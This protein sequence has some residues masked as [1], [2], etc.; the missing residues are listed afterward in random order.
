MIS[1]FETDDQDQ[2]HDMLR[3]TYT[4]MRITVAGERHH[5][6]IRRAEVGSIELHRLLLGMRFTADVAPMTLVP[7]VRIASG[8]LAQWSSAQTDHYGPGDLFVGS[9]LDHSFRARVDELDGEHARLPPDLLAQVADAAPGRAPRPIQ[10]TGH[11]PLSRRAASVWNRSYDYV[12]DNVAGLSEEEQPLLVG[13]AV[14]LLAAV[15]LATFPN[16][17]M[18]EPTYEDRHDSHPATLRRAVA[19]IETNAHRDI[20]PADISVAARVSIRALQL[21]FRRHLDTTP[22]AYLRR[23]RLDHAHRELLVADP[24]VTSVSA[25]AMRW[26]F[27]SHSSFTAHY[28]GA[29]GLPPSQTLRRC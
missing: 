5:L 19:F 9:R 29:F 1:E 3:R 21:A 8:T 24:A 11:R 26:G 6:R 14:Q 7:I 27:A 15:T 2:A 22:T 20:T 10:F 25:V 4:R 12:R 23:V 16:T 18:H 13:S 17:A 28:R